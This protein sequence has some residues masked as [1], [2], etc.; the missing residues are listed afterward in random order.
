V[1]EYNLLS[2]FS[3]LIEIVLK[4]PKFSVAGSGTSPPASSVND[5]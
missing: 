5:N 1:T 3:G 4:N 2:F